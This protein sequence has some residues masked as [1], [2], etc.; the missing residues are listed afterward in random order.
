[1][2]IDERLKAINYAIIITNLL[3]GAIA[4]ILIS[5]GKS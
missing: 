2:S 3:L 4:G 1:M 5:R